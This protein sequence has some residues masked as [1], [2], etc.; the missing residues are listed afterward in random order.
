MGPNLSRLLSHYWGRQQ[1]VPKAGWFLGKSF[2]TGYGLTQGD[3]APPMIFNIVVDVVVR[4]VL[5]DVCGPQE[6]QFGLGWAAGEENIVFYTDDARIAGRYHI[7]VQDS[8]M[9]T[10]AM[11]RRMGLETNL[12]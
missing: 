5:E 2:D 10:V 11:F 12:D 8:L 7:W 9:V 3:P 6:S 4:S 1:I